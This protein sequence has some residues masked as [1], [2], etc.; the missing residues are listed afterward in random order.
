MFINLFVGVILEGFEN[1][2]P[3]SEV[4]EEDM[5]WF[6]QVWSG[7]DFDPMAT[8]FM[9]VDKLPEFTRK[10]ICFAPE[11]TSYNKIRE[12]FGLRKNISQK[13]VSQRKLDRLL[14]QIHTGRTPINLF[15]GDKISM[16]HGELE[17]VMGGMDAAALRP[18]SGVITVKEHLAARVLFRAIKKHI[19]IRRMN[20]RRGSSL[21]GPP[22]SP[23]MTHEE[24]SATMEHRQLRE[25]RSDQRSILPNRCGRQCTRSHRQGR[26]ARAVWGKAASFLATNRIVANI[27]DGNEHEHERCAKE[28]RSF[29]LEEPRSFSFSGDV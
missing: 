9:S 24:W 6:K 23:M 27:T 12:E 13:N 8:C 3:L 17:H 18:N 28:P 21:A 22:G 26:T 1:K 29:S 4:V 5:E 25:E 7:P 2:D 11:S 15:D 16:L 10:L 19:I 20:A 14:D